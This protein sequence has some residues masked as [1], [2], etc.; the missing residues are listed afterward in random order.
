MEQHMLQSER[1]RR[2]ADTTL[3]CMLGFMAFG[4]LL[5]HDL[6]GGT[7]LSHSAWDSYTLQ[8]M[9]WRRGSLSR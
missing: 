2:A 4:Y 9:A 7:L 8:A 1:R 3:L 6:F 5:L